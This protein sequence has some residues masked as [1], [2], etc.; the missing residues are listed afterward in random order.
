MN[1]IIVELNPGSTLVD[2]EL[3]ARLLGGEVIFEFRTFPG[4]LV[5]FDSR[6]SADLKIALEKLRADDRVSKAY[7]D[8][9]VPISQGR[10][11]TH[12]ETMDL[13]LLNRR[14]YVKADMDSAWDFM[15]GIRNLAPVKIAV[16]DTGFVLPADGP[17]TT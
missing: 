9:V 12:A 10:T 14:A 3:L 8:M 13:E 4:Y 16:V 2:A 11:A 1:R 15:N 7:A 6:S 17:P 5:E